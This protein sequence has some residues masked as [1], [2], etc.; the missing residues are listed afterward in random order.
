MMYGFMCLACTIYWILL[1]YRLSRYL[2][3]FFF[4]RRIHLTVYIVCVGMISVLMELHSS[5]FMHSV[6]GRWREHSKSISFV[7]TKL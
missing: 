1:L 2:R 5:S 7:A 4:N 3:L 6:G